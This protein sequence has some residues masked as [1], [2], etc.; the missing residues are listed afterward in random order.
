MIS[1]IFATVNKKKYITDHIYKLIKLYNFN[2][3][4]IYYFIDNSP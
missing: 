1:L 2:N 4:I 3:S